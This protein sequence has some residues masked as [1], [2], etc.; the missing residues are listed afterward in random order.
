MRPEHPDGAFLVR[1]SESS[2]GEFSISVKFGD[3]V[4][5][6]KV[7]RDGAGHYYLWVVKFDSINQLIDYHRQSSVSRTQNI[8]LKDMVSPSTS[9]QAAYDFEPQNPDE[10]AF[11]KHDIIRVIE[12]FDQNWWKGELNGKIG[13]FPV[14]Y[15]KIIPV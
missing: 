9:V 13:V 5:H 3:S 8:I 11:K 1:D 10:L 12:K 2:P 6:F 4:Q 15:V 14:T 7:L